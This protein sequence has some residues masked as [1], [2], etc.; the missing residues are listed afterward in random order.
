MGQRGGGFGPEGLR[1][2]VQPH[3]LRGAPWGTDRG[4]KTYSMRRLPWTVVFV[5]DRHST[6]LWKNKSVYTF[7]R[8]RSPKVSRGE[9][10]I[11]FQGIRLGF[12]MPPKPVS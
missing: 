7:V 8:K 1:L 4:K 6:G 2:W 12:Q 10:Q 5:R 9:K 11:G 3:F